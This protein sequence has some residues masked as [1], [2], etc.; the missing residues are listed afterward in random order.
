[1]PVEG[2]VINELHL[3]R[4]GSDALADSSSPALDWIASEGITHLAIHFDVDVLDPK[5][6]G[7]ILFN[8]PYAP[9]NFLADVP[10]G[11]M[12]PDQVVRLVQN[13][14][15]TCDIVGLAIAE[16]LPWEAIATR[17]LL[18]RLPLLAD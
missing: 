18:S 4:T 1:M 14:A 2:Q 17:S 15:A 9:A 5:K 7:P 3:H 12:A 13:V 16:Y 10:R 6:F 11:R 8:N